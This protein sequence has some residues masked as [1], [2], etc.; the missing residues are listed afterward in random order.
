VETEGDM[1]QDIAE[2]ILKVS[3]LN[4]SQITI[5]CPK[6]FRDDYQFLNARRYQDKKYNE[7]KDKRVVDSFI[8]EFQDN[9]MHRLNQVHLKIL[10]SRQHQFVG[11]RTLALSIKFLALSMKF[12][13]TRELIKPEIENIL[14]N[15]SLPLF[16]TSEKDLSTFHND[17]VEYVRLQVD[18]QNDF[19]VKRQLSLLVEKMCALR[20]GK[21]KDKSPPIFLKNYLE[22]IASNLEQ[23]R[24]ADDASEALLYAFGNLK[25]RCVWND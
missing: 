13:H 7:I 22:T 23:M 20:Y 10:M 14:F 5:F 25:D 17:P 16:L 6:R 21:R 18:H 2:A 4:E 19:N 12:K 24:G 15:I 3:K 9:Y 8:R 11:T 1:H